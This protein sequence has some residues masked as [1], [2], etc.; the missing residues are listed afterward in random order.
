VATGAKGEGRT[1]E[2]ARREKSPHYFG[3]DLS[4]LRRVPAGENEKADAVATAPVRGSDWRACCS[5]RVDLPLKDVSGG[6][7]A[8]PEVGT[9]EG[10][11]E[12]A[13]IGGGRRLIVVNPRGG[14]RQVLGVRMDDG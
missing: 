4:P 14:S 11:L 8:I 7:A 13:S 10:T 3:E 1:P 5:A 6:E 9:R 2:E 12:G